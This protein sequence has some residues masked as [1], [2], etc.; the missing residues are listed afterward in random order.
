MVSQ[1]HVLTLPATQAMGSRYGARQC[2]GMVH[3]GA[4]PFTVDEHGAFDF[5]P[6][7]VPIASQRATATEM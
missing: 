1:V 6:E 2:S 7:I 4:I 3:F 5:C